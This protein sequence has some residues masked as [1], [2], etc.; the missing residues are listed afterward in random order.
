MPPSTTTTSRPT[1][2]AAQPAPLP[3]SVEQSY[4]QK[5]IDLKRRMAEVDES[6]DTFRLRKVRLNRG[7]VKLRLERAF[8]LEQLAMRTSRNVED[9][10]GSP[11]PPPTPKEKPLRT[12]RGHRRPDAKDP[13]AVDGGA[14]SPTSSTFLPA[15]AVNNS[16]YNANDGPASS[17]PPQPQPPPP[18]PPPQKRSRAAPSSGPKRSYVR[19]PTS[20][21][22]IFAEQSRAETAARNPSL[23]GDKT[24]LYKLLAQKWREMGADGQAKWID[25]YEERKKAYKERKTRGSR[26]RAVSTVEKEEGPGGAA[27]AATTATTKKANG[28]QQNGERRGNEDESAADE[29]GD[30][31]GGGGGDAAADGD[32]VMRDDIDTVGGPDDQGD[33][34]GEREGDDEGR[35]DVE[36]NGESGGFTAVNR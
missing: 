8:L 16:Y 29:E 25:I 17:P 18:P 27:A 33:G 31:A 9:S 22:E 10:E 14:V 6:N 2:Q 1:H 24:E 7:I 5:C 23:Q 20:A 13:L 30:A 12:K 35:S 28:K 11:S 4:R 21:Y 19:R 15:T 34:A 3:P 36:P 32:V 26:A